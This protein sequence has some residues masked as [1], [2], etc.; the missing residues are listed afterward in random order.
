MSQQQE[1]PPLTAVD[2][3]APW[4]GEEERALRLRI[5]KA[6]T[7]AARRAAAERNG[8]AQALYFQAAGLALA[9]VF[10]RVEDIGDLERILWALNQLF[11]AADHIAVVEGPDAW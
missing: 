4:A 3:F 8:R 11:M 10:R 7:I 9:W 2:V 1:R 6:Q 5:H